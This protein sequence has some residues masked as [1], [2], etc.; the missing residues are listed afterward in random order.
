MK[1]K[2]GAS[3][4]NQD[5][6]QAKSENP[7]YIIHKHIEL[8]NIGDSHKKKLAYEKCPVNI[9]CKRPR[10]RSKGDPGR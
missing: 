5:E 8:K 1:I 2:H 6:Y 3:K 7:D 9:H 10:Q 4:A